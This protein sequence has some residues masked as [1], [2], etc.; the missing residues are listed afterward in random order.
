MEKVSLIGLGKLGLS[1]FATIGSTGRKVLG[2]DID[3]H[4]VSSVNSGKAP[5][6]EPGLDELLQE[7][8]GQTLEATT[9]LR[10]A[11]VETD[12]TIILVQTPS[13]PDGRYGLKALYSVLGEL[14]A[15]IRQLGK[16]GHLISINCTIQPGSI[17]NA[18]IPYIEENTG[19][20]NGQDIFVS[21]NPE[22]VA[23]GTTIKN[24]Q[25]PDFVLIGA[26]DEITSQRVAKLQKSIIK[27]DA[28]FKV[29]SAVSAEIVKISLNSFL[30][31][32]ISFANLLSQISMQNPNADIDH[33]T[34]AI[35]A[36][37]R[38]G[39]K[40]LK[41]GNSFGGTCFPRDVYAFQRLLS[42]NDIPDTMAVAVN[43]INQA[44]S[45][46]LIDLVMEHLDKTESGKV[47][48]LGQSF[49][50]DT[51]VIAESSAISLIHAL[52]E[53]SVDLTVFDQHAQG[54]VMDMFG[55][56]LKYASS[57]AEAIAEQPIV[58]LYN[59]VPEYIEAL[60]HVQAGTVIVDCWRV[61][62]KEKLTDG[63][64]YVPLGN[65]LV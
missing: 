50:P 17:D 46:L 20:T 1:L 12:Y 13:E 14:C 6:H 33:I 65:K 57:A 29:M 48:I 21:Y 64:V 16:K 63:A 42:D 8:I 38:I 32:K 18:I 59:P 5:L 61:I 56:K 10:R 15:E 54:A 31:V 41:A 47:A 43:E 9:E 62:D 23:L 37:A 11:V 28:E 58:V 34:E 26:N 40:F 7:H 44:Q 52:L 39:N 51:H 30:T 35:G 55:E 4:V 2:V 24:F 22:M 27:N 25:N 45:D 49:K 3:E 53:R 60:A 36:D 19:C